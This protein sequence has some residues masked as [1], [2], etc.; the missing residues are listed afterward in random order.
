MTPQQPA[1]ILDNWQG[2]KPY[3][4]LLVDEKMPLRSKPLLSREEAFLT[5]D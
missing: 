3:K 5:T 4:C 1:F 2:A